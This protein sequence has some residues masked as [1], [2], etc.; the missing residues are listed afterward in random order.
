MANIVHEYNEVVFAWKIVNQGGVALHTNG[1]EM[2]ALFTG[3]KRTKVCRRFFESLKR[4]IKGP[5]PLYEN[6]NATIQ[7]SQA[8]KLIPSIKNLD[9]MI[10][11]LHEQHAYETYVTIC[12]R[13]DLKKLI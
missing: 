4:K 8:A 3:V 12:C 1:L 13:T 10:A 2:R 9:I 11:W 7:Q 5:T 6:N